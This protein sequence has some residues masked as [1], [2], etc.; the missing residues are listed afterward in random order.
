MS[1]IG[2]FD[3][4]IGAVGTG[5]SLRGVSSVV[6]AKGLYSAEPIEQEYCP[7]VRNLD[8]TQFGLHDTCRPENFDQ[9]ILIARENFFIQDKIQTS[10]GLVQVS[11][12][13]QLVLGAVQRILPSVKKKTIL[14]LGA[15][16]K[17]V[18]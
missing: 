8:V 14:A 15:Q 12:S 1:Q 5:H 10:K 18:E 9:R 7:G 17:I 13:F 6:K 16:N 3:L 2:Q 4:L 11:D